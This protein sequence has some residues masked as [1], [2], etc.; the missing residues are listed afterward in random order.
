CRLFRSSSAAETTSKGVVCTR[1]KPTREQKR[2]LE[3]IYMSGTRNPSFE[4][5]QEITS[6]LQRYGWVEGKNV[7]D[8]FQHCNAAVNKRKKELSH[9]KSFKLP[10]MLNPSKWSS[11]F[12]SKRSAGKSSATENEVP[13][14]PRRNSSVDPSDLRS[15]GDI[16]FAT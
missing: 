12:R 8:W 3:S 1:W 4:Q 7:V 2:I 6:Q 11:L 5:I 15:F 10:A 14:P 9:P 16:S 13:A